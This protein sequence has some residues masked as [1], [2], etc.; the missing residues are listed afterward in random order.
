MSDRQFWY[1][2]LQKRRKEWLDWITNKPVSTS[3]LCQKERSLWLELKRI[4]GNFY[5]AVADELS[6]ILSEVAS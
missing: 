3:L 4:E 6:E 5:L 2:L 1:E